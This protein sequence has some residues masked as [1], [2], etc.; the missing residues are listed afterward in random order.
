MMTTR[1]RIAALLA[2]PMAAAFGLLAFAAMASAQTPD[3][4]SVAGG[5][6]LGERQDGVR[7]FRGVPYAAAPVGALRWRDPQ[8]APHWGGDRPATRFAPACLQTGTSM[9]GEPPSPSS[10]DCLYLNVWAPVAGGSPKPVIVWFPGGGLANGSTSIPLYDGA[11]L[12]RRGAVVITVAYRLGALGFLAHPALSAESPEHTSG[13]YG[14]MDQVAAL[15]WVKAN[16]AVFG[17]D[18][19]RVTIAGQSA[20]ATSVSILMASPRAKGLF[21]RAIG[22]SGGLFE[23]TA[24][25]P[26]YQLAKA[27]ADGAAFMAR[28]GATTLEEMRGLPAERLLAGAGGVTHPVIEPRLLP[29]APFEVFRAGRQSDVPLLVGYNAEE[30]RS[31]TEVAEVTAA[32][33]AEKLAAR[34]GRLPPPLL[35]PYAFTNDAEAKTARLDFERDLR[36]GWDIRTWARLQ[37]EHGRSPVY[38]YR[39]ERRPPWPAGSVRADWGAS[40]FAD[41]W[42]MFDHLDSAD[43][44]W[45]ASD[46]TLADRMAEAWV[47]FA[48]TGDPNGGS[49]R[50]WTPFTL[51]DPKAMRLGETPAMG[52]LLEEPNFRAFDA[53]YDSL[54]GPR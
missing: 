41:L 54:R 35:A 28:L 2:A 39:F 9:P 42:Y 7:V 24:L 25:A 11:A 27:E 43:G 6:L 14:L 29:E 46:R 52:D 18:P 30:A 12:A 37:A 51:A 8:P 26:Q 4:V 49:A 13:N 38:L 31:L 21:Q 17:G 34:W 45:T 3:R 32:N 44:D 16:A 5:R 23:P 19:D 15:E 1:G 33:F 48:A 50:D 40:H 47:A 20:G 36:F 53:V 22:Q 10:E